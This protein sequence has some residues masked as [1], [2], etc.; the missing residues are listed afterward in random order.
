MSPILP[1]GLSASV[2]V[3]ASSANLGPG[4]DSLGIALGCYDEIVVTTTESG[5]RVE[6][7]GEGAGQV[8]LGRE[9]LVVRSVER[10]LA[11]LGTAARGL[12]VRCRNDI[13]HSRGL[14]SSAAA[15]VGGL[16]QP[17]VWPL[18]RDCRR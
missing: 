6:V 5:L 11:A 1:A 2:V 15:V 16:G 14:G 7:E 10:G 18:E 4:F 8:P 3:P 12:M 9:H 17:L 13:P